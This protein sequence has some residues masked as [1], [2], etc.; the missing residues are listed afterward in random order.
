MVNNNGHNSSRMT[1][2]H[3]QLWAALVGAFLFP[4]KEIVA[5]MCA[6]EL[7]FVL[8]EDR[9]LAWLVL[10][11]P[12]SLL[13]RICRYVGVVAVA[14]VDNNHN[15]GAVFV[16]E[17]MTSRLSHA[18]SLAYTMLSRRENAIIIS[19]VSALIFALKQITIV[20]TAITDTVHVLINTMYA[21][22]D[23]VVHSRDVPI[24]VISSVALGY[25]LL[26]ALLPP[27]NAA[28]MATN[29]I[30]V[31]VMAWL[32]LIASS[33][34]YAIFLGSPILFVMFIGLFGSSLGDE[35]P[36][37]IQSNLSIKNNTP[38]LSRKSVLQPKKANN[39]TTAISK[40]KKLE[41]K[42]QRLQP[43]A[44]S[45]TESSEDDGIDGMPIH[46]NIKPSPSNHRLSRIASL[47]FPSAA[48]T[49][50]LSST[51]SV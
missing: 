48:N 8:A 34:I 26:A 30:A 14:D 22:Q 35:K 28:K 33:S 12:F 7:E 49:S 24:P 31:L 42:Q 47:I 6:K 5:R 38:F 27:S 13:H 20:S 19:L 4:Y 16:F 3:S 45:E 39:A 41:R 50:L 2:L 43:I 51:F 17:P 15:D 29:I 11:S 36:P 37:D 23:I 10:T 25:I 44:P 9:S 32:F 18:A 40:H 21:T 46:H 1:P